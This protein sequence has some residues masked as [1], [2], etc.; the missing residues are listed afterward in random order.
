LQGS[1]LWKLE[2]VERRQL[3]TQYQAWVGGVE[4]SHVD[5]FSTGYDLGWLLEYQY[6]SR[7]LAAT[8]PASRDLFAGLRVAL[9]DTEGSEFL[10]GLLQDLDF[11]QEQSLYLE[12][13]TRLSDNMRLRLEA[14]L[15]RSRDE[16]QPLWWVAQDD[17]LQ[18]GV[19]W[20]F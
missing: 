12:G 6:D 4:Y 15:W 10:L 16:Q 14:W 9:N 5:A 19:D 1:W 2:A 17:Y 8:T 20:Y 7:Q 13:S 18:L 3:A 11:S